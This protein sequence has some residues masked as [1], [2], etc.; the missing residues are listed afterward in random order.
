MRPV[1][2]ESQ[3]PPA[4]SDTNAAASEA[5]PDSRRSVRRNRI[6]FLWYCSVDELD[7]RG[8][9]RTV[10]VAESGVGLVTNHQLAAGTKLFMVVVT[11]FGRVAC[12]GKVMHVHQPEVGSYRVGVQIEVIPPT[13]RA[14]WNRLL[15]EERR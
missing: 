11:R 4:I 13:D 6:R 15:Q 1:A 8:L 3:R 9:A 14:S 12:L 10:D 7:A 2:P 5:P